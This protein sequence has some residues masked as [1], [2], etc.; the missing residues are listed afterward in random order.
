MKVAEVEGDAVFF[1]REEIPSLD[2]IIHQA[3]QMFISF[4]HYLRQYEVLRICH[5][6][7]CRTAHQ[8][9]LKFIAHAGP[10]TL[11]SINNQIKPYGKDVITAHRLLKNSVSKPEYLLFS[12]QLLGSFK[13]AERLQSFISGSNYYLDDQLEISYRYL[14]MEHLLQKIPPVAHIELPQKSKNPLRLNL[15]INCPIDALYEVLIDIDLKH[16]WNTSIKRITNKTDSINKVGARHDCLIS[17]GDLGFETITNHFGDNKWVVGER[18]SRTWMVREADVYYLLESKGHATYLEMEI[19][20]K[21]FSSILYPLS[22]IYR[23]IMKWIMRKNLI[24]LKNYCE[25]TV[26]Q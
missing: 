17:N 6:G 5:C 14:P 21:P 2:E 1:Y 13:E 24:A 26:R 22:Y 4:H 8:L 23:P 10:Y 15:S 7:A 11:I 3:E 25:N 19:H 16:K 12:E 20:I 18:I 9:S